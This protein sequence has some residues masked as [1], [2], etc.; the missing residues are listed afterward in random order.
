M[1]AVLPARFG[2][3][4]FPGKLLA[5]LFGRTVLEWTWRRAAALSCLDRVIIATDDDRIETEARRFGAEV[6]RTRADHPSGTDRVWEAAS[7]LGGETPSF[8]VNLQG[9]EPRFPRR[10]VIELTRSLRADPES[11]WTVAQA[12]DDPEDLARPQVVKVAMTADFRALYFSRAAIPFVRDTGASASV[13][14][15]R[16]VG[17]YGYP[18]ELLRRFVAAPPSRLEQAEAL[19]QLRALELG[20]T[21]RVVLSEEGSPGI[22]T[23]EDLER[24]RSGYS[25]AEAFE[26]TAG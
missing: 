1:V 2:A 6:V 9:D 23:P 26:A 4:R 3:T 8:I 20:M 22:D 5:E 21:I 13:V 11:I 25:S 10:A 18:A 14:R 12:I 16:H 7:L 15:Y 24:L 19:E 17:V